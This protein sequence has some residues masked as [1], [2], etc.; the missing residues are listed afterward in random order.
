MQRI[1]G[2]EV[3]ELGGAVSTDDLESRYELTEV[4]PTPEGLVKSLTNPGEEMFCSVVAD[5]RAGKIRLA[6]AINNANE[7]LIDHINEEIKVTDVIAYPVDLVDEETGELF[8]TL[9]IVLIDINNNA[10]ACVSQGITNSLKR[11]FAIVGMP[12]WTGKEVLTVIPR[13]QKTRTKDNK[14]MILEVKE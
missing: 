10:F 1:K 4:K 2:Q 14:V 7:K 9:R 12:P 6:N 3:Q 11:I 13:L 5:S 8:T